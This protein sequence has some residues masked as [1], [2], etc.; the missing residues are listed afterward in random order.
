MI[1]INPIKV[2]KNT[3]IIVGIGATIASNWVKDKEMESLIDGK[4]KEAI[5]NIKR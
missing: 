3:A 2:I 5:A 4:V 1:N